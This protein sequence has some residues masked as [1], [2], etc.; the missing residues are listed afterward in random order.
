MSSKDDLE[1][2]KWEL[3]KELFRVVMTE[4]VVIQSLSNQYEQHEIMFRII[5][6]E[7]EV[8][9]P[10]PPPPPDPAAIERA[11]KG[12]E[13]LEKMIRLDEGDTPGLGEL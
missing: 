10:A 7:L 2:K 12:I 8:D 9:L 6:K 1:Q 5:A 3:L 11:A 13:Q 4:L